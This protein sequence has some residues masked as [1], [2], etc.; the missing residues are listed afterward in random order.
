MDVCQD[1][2]GTTGVGRA[3]HSVW[4]FRKVNLPV[5]GHRNS[6]T[7]EAGLQ[8]AP[9]KGLPCRSGAF[10]ELSP[11]G[12]RPGHAWTGRKMEWGTGWLFCRPVF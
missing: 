8:V 5:M 12:M 9:Q 11:Q 4:G 10:P 1:V 7:N 2:Y 6:S 3:L